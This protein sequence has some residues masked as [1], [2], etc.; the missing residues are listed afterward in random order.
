MSRLKDKDC[1]K[2]AKHSDLPIE[3]KPIVALLFWEQKPH[4]PVSIERAKRNQVETSQRK[5]D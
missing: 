3:L 4:K 1:S 5:I 2:E